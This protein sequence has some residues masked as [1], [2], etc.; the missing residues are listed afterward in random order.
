M[1]NRLQRKQQ[2][3]LQP[4]MEFYELPSGHK[5]QDE[6]EKRK[7]SFVLQGII[8]SR[9]SSLTAKFHSCTDPC[10]SASALGI[11]HVSASALGQWLVPSDDLIRG[12][13]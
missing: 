9:F 7:Y 2:Q 1:K 13:P 8:F 12:R 4:W 5:I 11:W 6:L 3:Q 10:V